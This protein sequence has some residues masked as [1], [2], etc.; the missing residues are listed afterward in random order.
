MIKAPDSHASLKEA[1]PERKPARGTRLRWCTW[2]TT[3]R[4]NVHVPPG[5]PATRTMAHA[6]KVTG[7]KM[8]RRSLCGKRWRERGLQVASSEAVSCNRC[9]HCNAELRDGPI[10][11]VEQV[12]ADRERNAAPKPDEYAPRFGMEDWE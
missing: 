12:V 2:S 7:G 8:A 3:D 4:R 9:P 10:E 5:C 6:F 11:E 1:L